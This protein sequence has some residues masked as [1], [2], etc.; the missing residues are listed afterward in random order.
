MEKIPTMKQLEK[1]ALDNDEVEFIDTPKGKLVIFNP[2][3]FVWNAYGKESI[4]TEEWLTEDQWLDFKG[5]N[6]YM[7]LN[8][9]YDYGSEL[10]EYC[11]ENNIK[12]ESD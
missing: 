3:R 6:D 11:K 9:E 8:L 7:F 10:V 4:D 12:M 2:D 1:I 5:S